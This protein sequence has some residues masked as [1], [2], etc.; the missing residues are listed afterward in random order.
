MKNN[1]INIFQS[2]NINDY[3]NI[4]EG[5]IEDFGFIYYHAILSW[6]GIIENSLWKSNKYWQVYLIKYNDDIVGICGL[7]SLYENRTDELW[8]GWFGIIPSE[9]NLGIGEYALNW[10]KDNA[11]LLGCKKIKSYVDKDGKPLNFYYRNGFKKICLVKEY[12]QLNKDLSL[13][14]FENYDDIIIEYELDNINITRTVKTDLINIM[15]KYSFKLI[16]IP[17]TKA[18]KEQVYNDINNWLEYWDINDFKYN[19]VFECDQIVIEPIREVDKYI[20][21]GIMNINN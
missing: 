3:K 6:C 5:L 16:K 1:N 19:L 18:F 17:H 12:L 4:L 14:E 8:L 13:D 11:K 15:E 10:M 7:Y 9:R 21:L 20:L 2:K